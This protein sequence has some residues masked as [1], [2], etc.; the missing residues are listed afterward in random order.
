MKTIHLEP[1][2]VPQ[3]LRGDYK[4]KK[5][6]ALVVEQ[7]TIPFDAGIWDGGSREHFYAIDLR[8]G[9]TVNFPGQDLSPW[10]KSR[11]DR[12]VNIVPGF[13]IVRESICQGQDLGVTFY[14]HPVNAAA[15]LPAP[16]EL[17]E[18]EQLVLEVTRSFKAS[19]GGKNRYEMARE[20][21]EWSGSK[22]SFPSAIEW[23]ETK[24]Q[25]FKK[26]LLNKAGA[27]T[28]KGRNAIS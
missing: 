19:Y 28:I 9:K 16:I 5:F 6:K 8:S 23:E 13:A 1:N 17:N 22:G 3:Q 15:M 27:I 11:A 21:W 14:V 20:R 24:L 26:G 7:A 12:K 2:Q 25:L 10:D 18:T 4:G